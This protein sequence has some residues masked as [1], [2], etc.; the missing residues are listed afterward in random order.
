MQLEGK[1]ALVTGSATGIG[2]AIAW[3]LP[4]GA[5][6]VPADLARFG[7]LDILVNNAARTTRSTLQTTD[8]ALFDEMTRAA[9]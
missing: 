3:S 5:A 6:F 2:E 4:G 9:P 7:R 1:I 8:A